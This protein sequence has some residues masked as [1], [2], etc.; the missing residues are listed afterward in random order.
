M[1]IEDAYKLVNK[2]LI[3]YNMQNSGSIVASILSTLGIDAMLFILCEHY[4]S[5][6]TIELIE[7]LLAG[8]IC[9]HTIATVTK[10]IKT[11]EIVL[12]KKIKSELE[13]GINRFEDTKKEDFKIGLAKEY[14]KEKEN[15]TS[16]I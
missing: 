1:N 13:L 4:N 11:E 6:D 2:K 12:L 7:C 8:G 14:I 3:L 10:P 5:Y 15:K 9:G 16:T